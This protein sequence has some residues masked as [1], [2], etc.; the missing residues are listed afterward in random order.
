METVTSYLKTLS[1]FFGALPITWVDFVTLLVLV[2]GFIRGRK[3]GL[4]EEILDLFQWLAIVAVAGLFYKQFA[5]IIG[6]KPVLS[7]LTYYLMAYI[8]LVMLVW[9]L[10]SA[11]KKRFGQ[12]LIESDIFGRFEFYGGMGAGMVRWLCMYFVLLS[13]LH[14]PFYSDAEREARRREV[15]YNY[16]SDFFPSL[17]KIQDTVFKQSFTGTSAQKYLDV[18]LMDQV[19]GDAQALRNENSMAKRRE[20]VVDDVMGGR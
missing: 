18:V 10:F 8:T 9:L 6:M 3:R 5:E 16:G 1:G 15:E 17:C 14:A 4:S 7:R 2:V 19:S 20:R 12:K 11:L 13:L